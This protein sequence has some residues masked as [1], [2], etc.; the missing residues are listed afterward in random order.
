MLFSTHAVFIDI[1]QGAILHMG[2][3]LACYTILVVFFANHDFFYTLRAI[4]PR[5]VILNTL[6]TLRKVAC[7]A[8][9]INIGK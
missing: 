4:R 6:L 2:G 1:I 7:V 8:R 5:S 3:E 9:L